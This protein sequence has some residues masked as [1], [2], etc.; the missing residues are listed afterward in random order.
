M[1]A[2]K[3]FRA[4][5][6]ADVADRAGYTIGAVYSNFAS[7]DALFRAL[8]SERLQRVEAD[9]AAAFS[10]QT[11]ATDESAA[12]ITQR[13][14]EELDRLQAAEDGVPPSWWRPSTNTGPMSPTIQRRG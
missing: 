10:G 11:D 3:G 7:K 13:I 2:D 1:F 8:M 4:A 14:D 6:I 5:T 12:A 9:L